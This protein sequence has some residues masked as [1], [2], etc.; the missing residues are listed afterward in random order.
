M[1]LNLEGK[2]ALITGGSK[3][4]GRAIKESLE[5]EGVEVT[6]LS[7][8]EG[9]NLMNHIDRNRAMKLFNEHEYDILINNMGGIGRGLDTEKTYKDCMEKNYFITT[10]FTREFLKTKN[11]GKYGRIITIASIYGKEAGGQPWFTAAKAA[12]IAYTKEISKMCKYSN[13]TANTISP[14]FINTKE[15]NVSDA[16]ERGSSAGTPENI[17]DMVTFLCSDKASFVNGTNIV[18]DGGFTN[19]F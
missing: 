12:Q 16:K 17:S 2:T 13:I 4:I 8:T 5:A 3:G 11:R 6:S 9:Y 1:K 18:I 14:G 10:K 15:S 7:R 19:S